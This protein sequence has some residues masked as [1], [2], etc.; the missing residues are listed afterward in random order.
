MF[1]SRG[2]NSDLCFRSIAMV[3]WRKEKIMLKKGDH[4][5]DVLQIIVTICKTA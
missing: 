4:I 5:R 2:N 1:L 3:M